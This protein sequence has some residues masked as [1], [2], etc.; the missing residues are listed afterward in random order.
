MIESSEQRV[1]KGKLMKVDSVIDWKLPVMGVLFVAVIFV[2]IMTV[3]QRHETR[4]SFMQLQTVEKERDNLAAKWSSLKLEQGIGV[5]QVHVDALA[6]EQLKMK[7][8]KVSEV[9]IVRESQPSI[10]PVAH[11]TLSEIALSD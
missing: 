8:P 5:N 4:A 10:V 6:V 1:T 3:V 11:A 7:L 9:R 2:A